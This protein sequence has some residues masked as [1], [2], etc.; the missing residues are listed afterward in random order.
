CGSLLSNGETVWAGRT[1]R[2]SSVEIKMEARIKR[3]IVLADPGD[4]DFVVAFG[5]NLPEVVFIQKVVTDDQAPFIGR[6]GDVVGSGIASE[7]KH[8]DHT[9]RVWIGDVEHHH[10]SGLVHRNEK[11]AAIGGDAH[12][13][14]PPAF[15]DGGKIEDRPRGSA[16]GVQQVEVIVEHSG[17]EAAFLG[18]VRD[19]FHVNRTAGIG[20]A[21]GAQDLP[22]LEVPYAH[23]AAEIEPAGNSIE[24]G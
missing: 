1:R 21:D 10:F 2:E 11:S 12:E 6:K 4:M 16:S 18:V 20:N 15:R 14:R 5:V 7:I 23:A 9:G 22:A 19:K 13:L 24:S 17:G 8:F 3:Q